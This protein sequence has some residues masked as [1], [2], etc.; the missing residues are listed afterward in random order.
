M[1]G[2]YSQGI[3]SRWHRDAGVLGVSPSFFFIAL[4]HRSWVRSVALVLAINPVTFIAKILLVTTV[5]MLTPGFGV[6]LAI[7]LYHSWLG[8]PAFAV[9]LWVLLLV[10]LKT[11]RNPAAICSSF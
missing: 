10:I 7:S 8:I 3:T 11:R 4:T 1:Y 5:L 9:G 6:D 2:L